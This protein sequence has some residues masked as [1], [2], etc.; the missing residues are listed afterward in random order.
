[1]LDFEGGV[2]WQVGIDDFGTVELLLEHPDLPKVKIG[3]PIERVLVSYTTTYGDNGIILHIERTS[4]PK[5]HCTEASN[6]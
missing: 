2:I 1:M 5:K 6:E 4:P 3:S